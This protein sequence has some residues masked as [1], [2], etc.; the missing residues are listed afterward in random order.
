MRCWSEVDRAFPVCITSR[1][2]VSST[3][4]NAVNSTLLYTP[5]LLDTLDSW[6][7]RIQIRDGQ[8]PPSRVLVVLRGFVR[9]LRAQ[10]KVRRWHQFTNHICGNRQ[11]KIPP[12]YLD[13]CCLDAVLQLL[14]FI[15]DHNSFLLPPRTALRIRNKTPRPHRMVCL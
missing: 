13:S 11:T 12:V 2:F 6:V 8:D 15:K 3:I 10:V 14:L 5:S 1:C 7:Q 9:A 4:C